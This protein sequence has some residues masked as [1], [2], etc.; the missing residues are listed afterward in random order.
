MFKDISD[1]IGFAQVIFPLSA[2]ASAVA[3]TK[4]GLSFGSERLKIKVVTSLLSQAHEH[5]NFQKIPSNL[6]QMS[7]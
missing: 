4:F 7:I 2:S 6:A 3:I 1:K 5:E